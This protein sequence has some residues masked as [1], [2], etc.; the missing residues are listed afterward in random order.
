MHNFQNE[1]DRRIRGYITDP[2]EDDDPRSVRL[3]KEYYRA[4]MNVTSIE[5]DQ[6]ETLKRLFDELGGWP[7]VR[8]DKWKES[9]FDWGKIVEKCKDVGFYYDWFVNVK[10]YDEKFDESRISVSR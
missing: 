2:I 5:D 4:C 3:Q 8:G 7:V 9:Q 6:N 1:I 10:N